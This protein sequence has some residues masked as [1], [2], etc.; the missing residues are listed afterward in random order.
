M[1]RVGVI[2]LPAREFKEIVL[3]VTEDAQIARQQAYDT[4][5]E[6]MSFKETLTPEQAQQIL[7]SLS[8]QQQIEQATTD[9]ANYRKLV[10]TAFEEVL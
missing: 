3:E 10:E 2:G 9:P 8:R 4:V 1:P 6:I 5:M 7:A